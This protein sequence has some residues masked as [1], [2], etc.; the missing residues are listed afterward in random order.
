MKERGEGKKTEQDR[1]RKSE[2]KGKR[3]DSDDVNSCHFCTRKTG[4]QRVSS[5]DETEFSSRK[6][7]SETAAIGIAKH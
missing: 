6:A 7:E 5:R 3:D 1:D 2:R 4:T